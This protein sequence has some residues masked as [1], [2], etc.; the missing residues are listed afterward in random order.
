MHLSDDL[1]KSLRYIEDFGGKHFVIKAGG[2]VMLDEDVMDSPAEDLAVSIGASRL[3]LMT[4]VAGILDKNKKLMDEARGFIWSDTASTGVIPRL[5][6]SLLHL[7]MIR[8]ALTCWGGLH[9][10]GS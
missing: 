1:M 4:S 2:K 8:N 10:W 6:A 9:C 7:S 3:I 5:R